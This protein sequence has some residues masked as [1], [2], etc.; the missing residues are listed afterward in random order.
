MTNNDREG[1]RENKTSP[2]STLDSD[3]SASKRERIKRGGEKE[4]KE[5]QEGMKEKRK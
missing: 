4:S 2:S 1:A 3:S 5:E